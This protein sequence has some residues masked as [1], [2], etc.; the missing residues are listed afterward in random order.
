MPISSECIDTIKN[1]HERLKPDYVPE[2]KSRLG[3]CGNFEDS[4]E[5]RTDAPPTSDLET[6]PL[7][8][9][10]AAA[11]G[12]PVESSDIRKA[13][14]QAE[15][16][17]RAVL[18][19]QPSGGLLEAMLLI[20][21]PVTYMDSVIAVEVFGG[22]ST[23]KHEASASKSAGSSLPFTFTA[24]AGKSCVWLPPTSMT[25]YGHRLAKAI[26]S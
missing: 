4:T 26:L 21:V 12:V 9:A 22:R 3:S 17:D 8:A 20:R 6:H 23:K 11:H 5:A 16:I 7:V 18:I 14:F 24:K 13:Y 25:S 10:F 19:R 1:F 2:F 15:P